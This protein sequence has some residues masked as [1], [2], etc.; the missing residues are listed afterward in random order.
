MLQI[1]Y[2]RGFWDSQ[3]H[4]LPFL[5]INWTKSDWLWTY[6]VGNLGHPY[7]VIVYRLKIKQNFYY[8]WGSASAL[9]LILNDNTYVICEFSAP[10][11]HNN[12]GTVLGARIESWFTTSQS[13][14]KS[15]VIVYKSCGETSVLVQCTTYTYVL[16]HIC[17]LKK[18]CNFIKKNLYLRG[19]LYIT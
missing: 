11:K 8:F 1:Y 3:D 19:H 2:L 15:K 5:W 10:P 13:I 18:N 4:Y 9:N 16:E 14:V 12:K 6:C 7:S 17:I